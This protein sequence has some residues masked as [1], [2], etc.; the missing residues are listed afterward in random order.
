[1]SRIDPDRR[2]VVRTIA[3]P[4][5]PAGL[6][7]DPTGPW[8]L[9][10]PTR[11]EGGVGSANAAFID[12]RYT[13]VTRHSVAL[14]QLFGGTDN[15]VFGAG[16]L[17]AVDQGYVTRLDPTTGKIPATI[18]VGSRG[19]AGFEATSDIPFGEGAVWAIGSADV[20]R[21]DP[22]TNGI[23]AKVPISQS[24]TGT[25]PNPTALA[26]GEGAVCGWQAG[27]CHSRRRPGVEPG[28]GRDSRSATARTR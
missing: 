26:V 8:V 10:A 2:V 13:D 23:V 11:G 16:S 12:A 14:R 6:A 25:P 18:R 20:V 9:Y 7:A 27:P 4:G 1:M 5:S 15:F 24:P 19:T 17:W 22:E 28:H 3:I 21:I